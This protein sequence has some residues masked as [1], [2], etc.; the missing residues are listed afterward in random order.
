MKS[1]DAAEVNV[2]VGWARSSVI[3]RNADNITTNRQLKPIEAPGEA[4]PRRADAAKTQARRRGG[5]H[6]AGAAAH[7]E[8]RVDEAIAEFL[9]PITQIAVAAR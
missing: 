9:C 6:G 5:R 1:I 2:T 4:R 7:Q 3:L 8:R